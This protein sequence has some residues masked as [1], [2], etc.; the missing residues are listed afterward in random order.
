MNV[1]GEGAEKEGGGRDLAESLQGRK[2]ELK[3]KQKTK[4]RLE[5]RF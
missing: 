4:P 1:A 5:L 3:K 2:K